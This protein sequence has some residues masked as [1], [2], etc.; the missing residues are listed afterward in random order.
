MS[1]NKILAS[2]FKN[3]LNNMKILIILKKEKNQYQNT[4]N[5]KT[6]QKNVLKSF[7]SYLAKLQDS[8]TIKKYQQMNFKET[9]KPF[10]EIIKAVSKKVNIKANRWN[11]QLRSLLQS[12]SLKLIFYDY[13]ANHSQLWLQKS[14][15]SNLDE[16]QR[17][18]DV[19]LNWIGNN[20]PLDIKYI[21]KRNDTLK[22]YMLNYQFLSQ[23]LQLSK[24]SFS[25]I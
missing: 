13:L 23:K 24:T 3:L 4:I 2:S 7:R 5:N 9:N 18:I 16:H 19:L 21:R 10:S 12:Q 15:V 1:N 14:K 11:F 6:Q 22:S 17:F 8:T 20:Q 25:T